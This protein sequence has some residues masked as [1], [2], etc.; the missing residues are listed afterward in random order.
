MGRKKRRGNK[1]RRRRRKREKRRRIKRGDIGIP[2]SR[3]VL[4]IRKKMIRLVA[5][6]GLWS[7]GELVRVVRWNC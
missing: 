5:R 7:V 3:R 4:V 1:K 6:G 2:G